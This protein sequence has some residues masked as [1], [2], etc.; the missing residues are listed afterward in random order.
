MIE[1]FLAPIPAL[2]FAGFSYIYYCM[3]RDGDEDFWKIKA[4]YEDE[5]AEIFMATITGVISERTTYFKIVFE[6]HGQYI[7]TETECYVRV[8]GKYHKGDVIP[9]KY[10]VNK[11]GVGRGIIMNDELHLCVSSWP[12]ATKAFWRITV[13]L[14]VLAG[15][16]AVRAVVLFLMV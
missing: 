6:Y 12:Q 15:V 3:Y 8:L 14:L 5:G 10:Y 11:S 7:Q 16:L 1:N 9:I 4:L 2:L 13:G